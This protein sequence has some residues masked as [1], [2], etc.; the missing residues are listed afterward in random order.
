[1]RMRMAGCVLV[2][3][4]SASTYWQVQ[5]SACLLLCCFAA[6]R[7]CVLAH[8]RTPCTALPLTLTFRSAAVNVNAACLLA[9]QCPTCCAASTCATALQL[10]H[11]LFVLKAF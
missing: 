5:A 11:K 3:R 4:M 1:M 10:L 8:K 6:V 7:L 2:V 9:A